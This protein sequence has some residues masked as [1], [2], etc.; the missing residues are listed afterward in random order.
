MLRSLLYGAANTLLTRF[1]RAHPLKT[2]ARQV[3]KRT[4]HKRA[5][6]AL[7][8]KLAVIMHAMLMSGEAFFWPPVNTKE[9]AAT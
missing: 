3:K 5:C 1:R 4:S 9:K 2:W 6:V 7:A 8:R